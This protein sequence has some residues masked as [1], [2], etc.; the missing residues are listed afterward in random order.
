MSEHLN[1]FARGAAQAAGRDL[2]D[3]LFQTPQG[4]QALQLT[5]NTAA[6]GGAAIVGGLLTAG[7]VAV[8][9]STA[10]VA[11]GTA[12]AVVAAPAVAIG[13]IGYGLYRLLKS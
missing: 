3:K 9:L 5:A 7:H 1:H 13:A 12:V 11:A 8:G 10:A 2:T 4:Q 6:Q